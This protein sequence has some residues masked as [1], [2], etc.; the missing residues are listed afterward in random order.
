MIP[1]G[2]ISC[3]RFHGPLHAMAVSVLCVVA[4][5]TSRITAMPVKPADT[6]LATV[7]DLAR[8][9]EYFRLR[10][11]VSSSGAATEPAWLYA[12]AVVERAFNRPAASN[13]AIDTALR[14]GDLPDSA[15]ARL[16]KMKVENDLRLQH[17]RSGL[18]A[19]DTLLDMSRYLPKAAIHDLRN[20]R[21]ILAVLVDVP[22]QRL[23]RRGPTRVRIDHGRIP[24]RIG[25]SARTYVFDTGANLSALMRSEATALGLHIRPAGIEVG[26]ATD[27]KVTT[28]LAVAPVLRIGGLEFHDVVFLVVDDAQL[29]FGDFR[30]PGIIGFPVIEQM[31]EVHVHT[32]GLLTVPV[33]QTAQ[34]EANFA[35]DG[36]TA[37]TLVTVRGE[38]MVCR[39]DTGANKTQLYEPF[40]RRFQRDLGDG[41]QAD[42]FALGGAGGVRHLPGFRLPVLE[43]AVGDTTLT[44][45][46]VALLTQPLVTDSDD[47]YLFCNVGQDVLQAFS[48]YTLDFRNMAFLLR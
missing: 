12:Q 23:V 40:Y 7:V 37:L 9:R 33:E 48:E 25:D 10:D 45:Q 31:G 17:Y 22:P 38:R 36:H 19:A 26:T 5:T 30:I 35:L 13:A 16:R 1:N 24:V 27:V 2:G 42:T 21:K 39:L 44:L 43:M 46:D 3:N 29:T 4:T 32:S 34:R 18:A 8:R 41:A 14:R 47:N 15:V 20:T 28:D 6:T 11:L